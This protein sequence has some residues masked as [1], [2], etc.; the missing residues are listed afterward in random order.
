[1]KII[2]V[3][4]GFSMV[5][6]M[7]VVGI[8]SFVIV[9]MVGL[10]IY[11][12]AFATMSGNMTNAV[13]EAQNKLEEIRNYDFDWIASK[14]NTSPSNV[15][16]LTQLTGKGCIYVDSS[17]ANLLIVEVDVSWKNKSNRTVGEDID[18][19]G[20]IDAGEDVNANGKLDSK[21]KL[22]TMIA[23]R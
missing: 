10:F 5:E 16:D 3:E 21:V 6:L 9:S 7:V 8:L 20:I 19:D 18:V 12:S 1:M 11:S 14:Y 13:G 23:K 4:S 15:F 22:I 2:K 17:N